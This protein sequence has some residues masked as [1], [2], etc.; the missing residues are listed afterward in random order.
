MKIYAISD[1]HGYID[2]LNE[3][4][5][6]VDLDAEDSILICLGDYIHG[7]DSYAVLDRIMQLQKQYGPEKVIT[8]MGN[9]E[10]AVCQGFSV[11]TEGDDV[12]RRIADD[13]PYIRWMHSLKEYYETETQ[14]FVH[15]GVDEEAEDL[16]KFGTPSYVFFGKCPPSTGWFYKDIIA[17][18]VGTATISGDPEFSDIYYD[19]AS[20][21]FI[22]GS[23]WKSGRIPVLMYDTVTGI[24]Y[25]LGR[26]SRKVISSPS[27]V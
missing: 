2:E 5:S 26:D 12:R 1:I 8:L 10:E 6:L 22:D 27:G 3:A 7:H 16:W 9:H 13:K 4:L 24:Y 21:Y 11:I 14:I 20:H 17:G 19:G 25:S 15:A 23:V 18:H